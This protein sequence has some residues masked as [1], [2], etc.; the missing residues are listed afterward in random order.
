MKKASHAVSFTRIPSRLSG[1]STKKSMQ[2]RYEPIFLCGYTA[3]H[4]DRI[5][6][7]SLLQTQN[8]H[9]RLNNNL[10]RAYLSGSAPHRAEAAAEAY[11]HVVP[12]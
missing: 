2:V 11:L 1:K 9:S 10:H 8:G 12:L 4:H 7:I 6:R 3:L 5:N